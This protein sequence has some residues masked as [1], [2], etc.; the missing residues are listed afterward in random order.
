MTDIIE[1]SRIYVVGY[2]AHAFRTDKLDE[3]EN[4][5]TQ[6]RDLHHSEGRSPFLHL[7]L[8]FKMISGLE[9]V[10][11]RSFLVSPDPLLRLYMIVPNTDTATSRKR[12]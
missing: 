12:T 1:I 5:S 6:N 4:N 3:C 2:S 7:Q 10:H 11:Y 9:Q 8:V